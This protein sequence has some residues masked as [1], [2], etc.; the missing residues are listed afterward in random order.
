[1]K[2]FK[3]I[4]IVGFIILTRWFDYTCTYNYTHDLAQETNILVHYAGFEWSGL[5]ISLLLIV[6]YAIYSLA[7]STYS[8]YNVYP[9]EKNLKY[10]DFTTY[11]Y[12]G[13]PGKWTMMFYRLPNSITRLNIIFGPI[14]A[15]SLVWAGLVTTTMWILMARSMMYAYFFHSPVLIYFALI[16]GVLVISKLRFVYFYRV[17]KRNNKQAV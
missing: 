7:L 2:T 4:L 5:L 1:M 14:M 17:Y 6:T 15:Y 12:L 10:Q 3:F 8:S 16:T 13:Y 11:L 9:Q